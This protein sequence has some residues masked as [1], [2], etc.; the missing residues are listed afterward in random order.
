ML[1]DCDLRRR[2]SSE[3]L[4]I[5]S[6]GLYDYFAGRATLDEALV[7]DAA[8][9]LYVLG[10]AEPQ[11]SAHDPLSPAALAAMIAELRRRFEVIVLDTAPILGVADARAVAAAVDRVLVI[12]R[13]RRTSMRACEAAIDL[14]LD[15]GARISGVALTQ[16]DIRR[17]ASTGHSDT[18]GYQKKFQGYYVN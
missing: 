2:G 6:N 13:W 8:T 17:Y 18:Y 3:L 9:G 4:R 7:L 11:P 15:V 1:V 12:T 14:L 10:T 5:G 16:V